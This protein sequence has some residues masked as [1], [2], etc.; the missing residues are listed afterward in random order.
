MG[1]VPLPIPASRVTPDRTVE[2]G[3][4]AVCW[5]EDVPAPDLPDFDPPMPGADLPETEMPETAPDVVGGQDPTATETGTGTEAQS[6]ADTKEETCED[7]PKCAA[8]DMGGAVTRPAPQARREQKRGYDYQHFIC[9]WHSYSPGAAQIEEWNFSGIDFEGLHPAFCHLFEAKHGYDNFLDEHWDG[10]PPTLKD[11]ARAADIQVF[12]IFV[13]QGTA[14]HG[15]VSPHYGE[16]KLTWIFSS[17]VTRLHVGS[18]FL[19]SIPTWY[20]EMEVR[21]F[22]GS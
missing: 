8:R 12:A 10:T 9:P 16:V 5:G 1:C 6:E 13:V 22:G 17:M 4:W 3:V 7:C 2:R 21:P 11:W 19:A 14:Q 18:L 20:H 15:A